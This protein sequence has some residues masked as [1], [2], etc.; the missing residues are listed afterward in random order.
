MVGIIGLTANYASSAG[1]L[2]RTTDGG[3]TWND[4]TVPNMLNVVPEVTDIWFSDSVNGWLTV[5]GIL[6]LGDPTLW[7]STDGGITWKGVPSYLGHGPA[8]V[9]MTSQALVVTE[10]TG[11]GIAY[12]T[13]TGKT[14]IS[15]G[16]NKNGLAFL[17]DLRGVASE[18]GMKATTTFLYTTDGGRN[19][20]NSPGGV[21]HEGFGVYAI[22]GAGIF[23]AAP[24]D[25]SIM[26]V[27]QPSKVYHSIDGNGRNWSTVTTFPINT[28][29]S[30][31]GVEGIIYV[32]S[33]GAITSQRVA[34]PGLWRSTD[35]GLTWKNVGGPDQ[36]VGLFGVNDTRFAVTGCGNVV[37]AFDDQGGI[38]K[39]TDAGDGTALGQCVFIPDTIRGLISS[40]ICD[41]ARDTY[42][43]HNKNISTITVLDLRVFD[44]LRRPYKTGSATID[45]IPEDF[46]PIIFPGD[47]IAFRVKWH[48][49]FMMDS[50][51]GDSVLVRVIFYASYLDK[52]PESG[53]VP[54]DTI[55]IPIR[56]LGIG[57][58]AVFS[59][60]PQSI[61]MDSLLTCIGGDSIIELQNLGCDSLAIIKTLLAKQTWTLTDTSDNP[62]KGS[63]IGP[64]G[65]LRF[66]VHTLPKSAS[67]LFDSLQVTMHYQGRDTAFGVA[68]RSTAK[69]D[70]LHALSTEPLASFD[71]VATCAYTDTTIYLKNRACDVL[72]LRKTD[73]SNPLWTLFDT[74]GNALALPRDIA[75]ND[76]LPIR[77]RFAPGSLGHKT[78]NVRFHYHFQGFD[79]SNLVNLQG[80]GSTSGKLLYPKALDFGS[81]SICSDTTIQISFRNTSCDS[82]FVDSI[83]LPANYTL[84]DSDLLVTKWIGNSKT[85]SFRVRHKPSIKGVETEKA[86][87]KIFTNNGLSAVYD[88]VAL[89]ITGIPGTAQFTTSNIASNAFQFA[90]RT[91][92]DKGESV[93]FTVS[94]FGCDSL[95][96]ESIFLDGNLSGAFEAFADASLPIV[97][98][99]ASAKITISLS[100]LVA[101]D[102]SG[103]IHIRYRL[104]DGSTHDTIIAP[105]SVSITKG[106]GTSSLS[107]TT[108]ATLHVSPIHACTIT[109]TTIVVKNDGCGSII[110]YPTLVQ[111][112]GFVI[113]DTVVVPPGESRT[114]HIAYDPKAS[115]NLSATFQL[116]AKLVST[117]EIINITPT[118]TV[119]VIGSILPP[120]TVNFNISFSKMPVVAGESFRVFLTPDRPISGKNLHSISG[121]LEYRADAFEITSGGLSA[122]AGISIVQSGPNTFGEIDHYRFDLTNASD[123]TLDP[124]THVLSAGLV[125]MISDTI[126]GSIWIDSL[127]LNATDPSYSSCTLSWNAAAL[128]ASIAL[129]C[130]DST[131]MRQLR[132][133]HLLIGSKIRPN[134]VTADAAYKAT[135]DLQALEDGIADIILSDAVGRE[136][137]RESI[138][139]THGAVLPYTMDLSRQQA[140]SYIY[141]VRMNGTSGTTSIEGTVV[142][143][144]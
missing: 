46:H 102:Y 36:G 119:I 128:S 3:N 11:F 47:S 113:V 14:W 48:P 74:T 35:S 83:L 16:N 34:Y 61:R 139:L 96:I 138:S 59:V 72:T 130:G 13:D 12:S 45:S 104:P 142:L 109:D 136:V 28:T 118:A 26:G 85:L 111:G 131:F 100:K 108:D 63:K 49:G 39:S 71:S 93:S 99:G 89:T 10:A 88:T 37:Y 38:W 123:I 52:Y 75:S 7:R 33:S 115:G 132:G 40:T 133:Q 50:T 6:N 29:G 51:A 134:P 140:G 92:C 82:A 9:R 94:N 141:T 58:K 137:S 98:Q 114:L 5:R 4:C 77:I 121:V 124:A 95:T 91:E 81:V 120:E 8:A 103:N 76:S 73:V 116:Q 97:M 20:M 126:G 43:L 135:I 24:E 56:L 107:M 70:S 143:L 65:K 129:Q 25:T 125:A 69:L 53:L 55:F 31:Q 87:L 112:S 84:L 127:K 42:F 54:Y 57:E 2:K 27:W 122:P 80:D 30:I 117:G 79:S 1:M 41:T 64:N 86:Y 144:K 67:V 23:V 32:Q 68:L 105:A 18:Y 110:V 60:T 22:K 78:G 101:G 44:T 90:A 15:F 106:G 66:K 62:F 21:Q 19:W 17:G